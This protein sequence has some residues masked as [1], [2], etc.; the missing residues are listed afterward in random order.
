[1]EEETTDEVAGI[2]EEMGDSKHNI[3]ITGMSG[4]LTVDTAC[5]PVLVS[6][7]IRDM[8]IDEPWSI[9]YCMRVIPIQETCSA[10]I[11][12]IASAA[13]KIAHDKITK[14][15]TYRITVEKRNSSLA[16]RDIIE[17]VA[18]DIKNKVSLEHADVTILI[19]VLGKI[20]GVSV[21]LDDAGIFSAEKT[22]RNMNQY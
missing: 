13:A 15:A 9:R 12:T 22:R 5:D 1:M 16:S 7:K 2:L 11:D 14:D 18:R 21:L 17:A 6:N 3:E 19:E 4:I 10:Q 8:L 20:A